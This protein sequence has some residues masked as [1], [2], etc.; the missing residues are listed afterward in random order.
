M[1]KWE[2]LKSSDAA[3]LIINE[4]DSEF[5]GA[6]SGS[7]VRFD[8]FTSKRARIE[9]YNR[10]CPDL[11]ISILDVAEDHKKFYGRVCYLND[12]GIAGRGFYFSAENPRF[13]VGFNRSSSESNVVEMK[14]DIIHLEKDVVPE[15]I[16]DKFED[17]SKDMKLLKEN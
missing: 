2:D 6:L 4:G 3:C 14:V 1:N 12:G 11:G 10:Y 5:S 13:D 7:I 16:L 8:I 17:L 15:H 9:F